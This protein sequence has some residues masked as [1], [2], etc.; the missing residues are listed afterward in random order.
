MDVE[1][2]LMSTV[3]REKNEP[4]NFGRSEAQKITRSD[5]HPIKVT[6]FRSCNGNKRVTGTGHY[7]W[8]S[9]RTQETRETTVVMA[10]QHQGC[11]RPTFGSFERNSTRQENVEEKSQ[12]RECTM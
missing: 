9:R 12:N 7:A 1:K 8:T 5:N 6:L 11:Y 10:C 4:I 3:D 2:N